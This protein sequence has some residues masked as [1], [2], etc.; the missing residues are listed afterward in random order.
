MPEQLAR[1]ARP[2]D[3][4]T[5]Y[6]FFCISLALYA[7]V[8][9]F[10]AW[11]DR[12]LIGARWFAYAVTLDL[13]KDLL[14]L[15]GGRIPVIF[16]GLVANEISMASYFAMY[17]GFRWFIRREPL[18]NRI[19]PAVLLT[20]MALYAVMY[21]AH[22]PYGFHVVALVV[23]WLCGASIRLMLQQKEERFFVPGRITA[24]LL[25]MQM[26]LLFYRA[27]IA[28]EGYRISRDWHTP[29]GDHRW[30][31]A[32]LLLVLTAN[33]LLLMFLWFAAAE[34]Y[35][36]VEASAGM[37]AL[38]GCLNRRSLMKVA[39]HEMARSQRTGMPLSIVAIDIDHFKLVNDTYGHGAG[40]SLL[41]ALVNLLKEHLRPA[42]V[43]ARTG[44][45]EFLLLLPDCEAADAVTIAEHLRLIIHQLRLPYEDSLISATVSMGVTQ[46]LP[47]NDSWTAMLNRADRAMYAAKRAGRNRV[48]LDELA[49][50]LPHRAASA[51]ATDAMPQAVVNG[52]SLRLVR[53]QRS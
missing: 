1:I 50:N 24:V 44:G 12:R 7:L 16:N 34:M 51:R 32:L 46:R 6:V 9:T 47:K 35:S 48:I 4:N 14:Q 21:L 18:S 10:M 5:A 42:D 53:R 49:T 28:V 30:T 52:S 45:E 11:A 25:F 31:N 2:M 40:D 22:I 13:V 29:I 37:D 17:M 20:G 15:M 3:L 33:C 43:L 41:C 38:T 23:M 19:R 26:L 39:A 8:L 27:I 36:T